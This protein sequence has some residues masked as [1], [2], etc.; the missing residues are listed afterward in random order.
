MDTTCSEGIH[1]LTRPSTQGSVGTVDINTMSL[2]KAAEYYAVELGW[3]VFPLRPRDKA[4]LTANGFHDATTDVEQIREWWRQWPDANIGMPTGKDTAV[5]LDIDRK[6]G[7]TDG[8]RILES[9]EAAHGM[10]PPLPAKAQTGG[11][12]EHLYFAPLDIPTWHTAGIDLQAAS[13]YVVL[14][15]SVHASGKRYS[16]EEE[17][18][19]LLDSLPQ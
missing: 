8:M 14:P 6:P 2:A 7:Q 11:G 19:S 13:A 15:P 12:G 17:P 3:K 9:L 10:L 16:W 18:D 4:P 1:R 5:V